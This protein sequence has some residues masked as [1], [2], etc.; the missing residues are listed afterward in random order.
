M[1]LISC[2]DKVLRGIRAAPEACHHHVFSIPR[3]LCQSSAP[4][5]SLSRTNALN[6]LRRGSKSFHTTNA[7]AEAPAVE[8]TSLQLEVRFEEPVERV[9]PTFLTTTGRIFAIG[10]IHGDINKCISCLELAGV[11][12]FSHGVPTWT[13]G[14]AIV[15]QLGD[16]LDRGDAEVATLMLLRQLHRQA[17]RIGGGVYVLNGNHESLNV[18]GDF[19]YV[20]EGAFVESGMVMGLAGPSLQDLDMLVR[21]RLA[22]YTPG[23]PMAKE[24]S[25]NPT[26]LVINDTVFAHGG[27][28]PMHVKYGLEKINAEVAAWMRADK[29]EEGGY[30]PPPFIAMGDSKAIMWNR[31]FGKEKWVSPVDR[32]HATQLLN[33]ALSE[34]NCNRLVVGH[35]PQM[36]GANAD[37][38]DKVWRLDVGM[39]RGMLDAPPCVMEISINRNGE[40]VPK[41]LTGKRF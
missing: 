16:I 33:T 26:A 40:S 9:P 10:D 36:E 19:R 27:L 24:L 1:R 37:C 8:Q 13:G 11:A 3:P 14:D 30:A 12:D 6:K 38:D 34:L 5:R 20:T 41:L 17:E 25:R 28:L 31:T 29:T 35:T 18:C 2:N 22:L 23:Q 4:P 39:S 32:I 15:V 7:V 21:A